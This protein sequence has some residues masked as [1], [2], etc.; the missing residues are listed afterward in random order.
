[1]LKDCVQ[2]SLL[3]LTAFTDVENAKDLM[4]CSIIGQY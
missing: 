4:A 1:M 2:L 3:K